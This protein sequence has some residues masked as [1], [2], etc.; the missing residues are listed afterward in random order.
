MGTLLDKTENELEEKMNAFE[1]LPYEDKTLAEL[2]NLV[3]WLQLF[4]SDLK[5]E[6]QD[7]KKENHLL[8]KAVNEIERDGYANRY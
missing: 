8:T 6:I 1:D 7:L 2:F 5:S 4:C 3:V